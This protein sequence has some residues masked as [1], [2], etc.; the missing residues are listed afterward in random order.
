MPLAGEAADIAEEGD[1]S[2]GLNAGLGLAIQPEPGSSEG[3][4]GWAW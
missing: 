2:H 1:T 3:R 4:S